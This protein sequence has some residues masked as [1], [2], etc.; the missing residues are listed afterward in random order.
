MVASFAEITCRKRLK[1]P[2]AIRAAQPAMSVLPES[3]ELNPRFLM[4]AALSG[5][6]EK[7]LVK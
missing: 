6:R 4:N 3:L 2:P 5:R 1:E 7:R